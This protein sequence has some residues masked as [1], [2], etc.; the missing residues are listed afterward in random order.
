MSMSITD[1]LDRTKA[2]PFADTVP[3]AAKGHV[4]VL[5]AKGKDTI[6]APLIGDDAGE[7]LASCI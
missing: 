4:A 5:T 7:M 6:W 1:E 3:R 2:M